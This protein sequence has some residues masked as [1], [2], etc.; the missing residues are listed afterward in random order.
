MTNIRLPKDSYLLENTIGYHFKNKRLLL[1]ALTHKSCKKPYNNERLEFLGDAVLDL[2]VGEYLFKK[3]PRAREGELSK[4]RACIVNETGFMR[5]A[6]S[7]NL[8][9]FIYI[10]QAEENNNGRERDSILSNAFEALMGAIYLESH[11]R[12]LSKIVYHLLESNY[13][14]IDLPSLFTDYKT[15]LQEITQALFHEV[16]TYTL[17]GQNGPDHRKVFKIALHIRGIEYAREI[18]HS[19]KEAQQKCAQIAYEKILQETHIKEPK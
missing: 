3:L 13:A 14:K 4:L 16:P 8:G 12:Y 7:I 19:K 15:A 9:D 18:G 10:S 5:L 6:K 1:E 17:I 2:L 11:L